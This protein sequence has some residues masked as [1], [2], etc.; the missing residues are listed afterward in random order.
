M[1]LL[2]ASAATTPA[3]WYSGAATYFTSA[4]AASDPPSR[5]A[6]AYS[7]MWVQLSTPISPGVVASAANRNTRAKATTLQDDRSGT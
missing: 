1:E 3:R 2:N 7:V 5:I 6:C 4:M